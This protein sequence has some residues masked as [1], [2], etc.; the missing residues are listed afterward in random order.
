M[1][2]IENLRKS[3]EKLL[4]L[5]LSENL[6]EI[7]KH[8]VSILTVVGLLIVA[9][10]FAKSRN[11]KFTPR[12]MTQIALT[13][14]LATVLDFFKIYRF[15]Q[16]GSITFGSMIPILLI[17]L[18]HGPLIGCLA[19]L[20]FGILSL[21]LGPYIVQPVQVLFDYPLPFLLLGTAG[22]FKSNKYIAA[23]VAIAL[24]FVCHVISGV[25]FFASYAPEG[26]SPLVYSMI[27]N[28]SFLSLELIICLVIL[29]VLPVERLY[30]AVVSA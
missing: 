27:Y 5:N 17:S 18:W 24:R 3:F 29:A 14:A 23:I 2:I 9:F 7:F 20:L 11:V 16:G 8:P 6:S 10:V 4:E 26:Q 15:P 22:F 12:L 1:S 30:K 21:I 19:G 13:V 25:V 28:G